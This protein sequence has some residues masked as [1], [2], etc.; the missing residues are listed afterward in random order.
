MLPVPAPDQNSPGAI[1]TRGVPYFFC[2]PGMLRNEFSNV[3]KDKGVEI[4]LKH[5]LY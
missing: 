5:Y 2:M 1:N 4:L 3:V